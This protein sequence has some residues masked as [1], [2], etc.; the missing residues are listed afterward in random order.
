[1]DLFQMKK[2]LILSYCYACTHF[3]RKQTLIKTIFKLKPV[4]CPPNDQ[5][6][7]ESWTVSMSRLSCWIASHCLWTFSSPKALMLLLL[8]GALTAVEIDEKQYTNMVH[9]ITCEEEDCVAH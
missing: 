6:S 8:D 5:P 2:I 3:A 7:H 9:I 4:Q 1:M